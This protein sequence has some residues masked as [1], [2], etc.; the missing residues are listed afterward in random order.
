MEEFTG[1]ADIA[2]PEDKNLKDD[3][4]TEIVPWKSQKWGFFEQAREAR[5][6]RDSWW[7]WPLFRAA[8]GV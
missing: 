8:W 6:D 7:W 1:L 3:E 5:A 4:S 2:A